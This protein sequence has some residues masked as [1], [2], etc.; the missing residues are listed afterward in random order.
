MKRILKTGLLILTVLALLLAAAT[1]EGVVISDREKAIRLADQAMEEKYGITLLH[2]EYFTRNTEE[3]DGGV[4]VTEY[5]G[6]GDWEYVL[7]CY[8]VT[9]ADGTVTEITWNRDGEDTSG[10]LD[11]DAWGSGQ[12]EEMLRLNQEEGVTDGFDVKAQEINRKHGLSF[13][14]P[15]LSDEEREAENDRQDAESAE[16]RKQAA[17]S[18]EELTEIGK[19]AVIEVFGLTDSQA[20]TTEN[21]IGTEDTEAWFC[22][23]QGI[24]CYTACFGMGSDEDGELLPSGIMYNEKEGTYW[25]YINVKTGAVEEILYST[26]I[27]GN[28]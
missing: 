11:A 16:A 13:A 21:L 17:L 4:F 8:E 12:I 2:Q 10:G 15:A 25:I 20:G 22:M 28:G 23:L 3:K 26:G 18:V 27:G 19:Q 9:V 7:G 24:P 6:M 14:R 5:K 1:A